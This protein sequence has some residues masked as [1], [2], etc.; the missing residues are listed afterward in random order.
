MIS[1]TSTNVTRMDSDAAGNLAVLQHLTT[2][3]TMV[4]I[5]QASTTGTITGWAT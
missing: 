5:T 3:S 4:A 1:S 2:G